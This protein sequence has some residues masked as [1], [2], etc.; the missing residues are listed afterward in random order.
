MAVDRG[1]QPDLADPLQDADEEGVDGDETAGVRGFD[2]ALAEL[3]REPLEQADLLVGEVELA[4][5]GGLLQPQQPLVLGEKPVAHPHPAD[6]AGRDLD[7]REP[8]LLLDPQLAVARVF[9]RV[10]EDSLLDLRRDPVRVRPL[11][12]R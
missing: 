5:G 4:L 1:L 10:V 11:R 6:A 2:V 9:E 12:P 3:R 8:Q 7:A